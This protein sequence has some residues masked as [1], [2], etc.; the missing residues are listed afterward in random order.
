MAGRN[1]GL[2][3]KT[4]ICPEYLDILNTKISKNEK[5]QYPKYFFGATSSQTYMKNIFV[6][7]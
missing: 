4:A 7:P 3:Y 1:L 2:E 6:A 5:F